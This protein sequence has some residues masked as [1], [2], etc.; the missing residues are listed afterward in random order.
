M[1]LF[2]GNQRSYGVY[3]PKTNKVMTEPG[4]P[5]I[6]AFDAHLTGKLGVGVVP[7]M[8]EDDC[9]WGAI[10]IDA[11]G[12]DEPDIDLKALEEG[13]KQEDFPLL[14]CRSKSGGAHLYLF[15][16]EPTPAKL[17]RRVLAK[18][19]G[20]L[21]FPGVE[22]F[23][24]QE[25]LP[26]SGGER[27]LGNWINL[28]YF[29]GQQRY[30]FEGGREIS[31]EHFL[32]TAESRRT[33]PATLVEKANGEHSEAPPCIQRMLEVGV[34]HG[35]RN[36]GLYAASVYFKKLDPEGWKERAY[37]FN[38]RILDEPLPHNEAKKTV[39]SAGRRDYR[40]R[41]KVEPC[42][43]LCNSSVCI[44]R[45]HGITPE[46]KG[47]LDIGALPEFNRLEKYTTDP[48]RW[49]LYVEGTPITL[50][51]L[52]LMDYRAVRRAVADNLTRIIAPLKNNTWEVMLHKLMIDAYVVEAPEEAST[53]GFIRTRLYEFFQ[54]TDLDSTGLDTEQRKA[55]LLGS[56][57][58]QVD[59]HGNRQ[60]YFRGPDFVDFLKKNRSEEL[61]GSNLWVALKKIGVKHGKMRIGKDVVAVW[62]LPVSPEGTVHISPVRVVSEL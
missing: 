15:M 5:D 20:M 42:R 57:T 4:R 50:S 11:H 9:W 26:T 51:T 3:F 61:K 58:V 44:T 28:P 34:K 39:T 59:E 17:I 19:A 46:E 27:Q 53:Y 55:L 10:D 18:W 1:N 14:V 52:E 47:E 30:A 2:R 38:A 22:I 41:C 40:Y 43:S 56:P 29:G 13:V 12:D 24:K 21:G 45:K 8:D 35:Y 7:I 48:V 6:V 16:T 62:Y 36:E 33:K 23:P 37:D 32:D 54:K 60:V 49:I 25:T 31:F